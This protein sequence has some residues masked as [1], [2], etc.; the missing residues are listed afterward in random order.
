[1]HTVRVRHTQ[2]SSVGKN[3][4]INLELVKSILSLRMEKREKE[5]EIG[6]KGEGRGTERQRERERERDLRIHNSKATAEMKRYTD[7]GSSIR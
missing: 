7:S 1:M 6:E 3:G 4:S 5:E 2:N